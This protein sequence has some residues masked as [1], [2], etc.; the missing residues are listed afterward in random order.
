MI[1]VEEFSKEMVELIS[2]IDNC[3]SELSFDYAF[4]KGHSIKPLSEY[5]PLEPISDKLNYLIGNDQIVMVIY[6]PDDFRSKFLGI[7]YGKIPLYGHKRPLILIHHDDENDYYAVYINSYSKFHEILIPLSCILCE[8]KNLKIVDLFRYYWNDVRQY[9]SKQ[10][11]TGFRKEHI[12]CG[13]GWSHEKMD[14]IKATLCHICSVSD[15]LMES[16]YEFSIP[17]HELEYYGIDDFKEL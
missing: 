15:D 9:D 10:K 8:F 11:S 6:L 14:I 12:F 5:V 3:L 13:L 17:E 16:D 7:N 1:D 4:F 2:H